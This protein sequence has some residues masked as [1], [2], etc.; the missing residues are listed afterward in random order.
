ML[1]FISTAFDWQDRLD[2]IVIEPHGRYMPGRSDVVTRA[3]QGVSR[4]TS[5]DLTRFCRWLISAK[6]NLPTGHPVD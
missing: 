3:L 6:I 2:S 1:R 4:S 5:G